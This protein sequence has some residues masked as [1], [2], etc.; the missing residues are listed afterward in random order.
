[1]TKEKTTTEVET[2]LEPM[3]DI[4]AENQYALFMQRNNDELF[5]IIEC[6]EYFNPSIAKK[7]NLVGSISARLGGILGIKD[8]EFYLAGYYANLSL[9]SM[10]DL[11]FKAEFLNDKEFETYKRHTILSSEF[12]KHK[13]LIK[14][15]DYVLNHHENPDASGYF[16]KQS[17]PMESALIN[18]ADVFENCISLSF[19]RPK[20]TLDEALEKTLSVY[21]NELILNKSQ[22]LEIKQELVKIYD[23]AK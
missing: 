1:M 17:Y 4:E 20:Y 13:G 6:L 18:I 2:N 21:S 15:S 16:S 11:A 7:L 14:A 10:Q 3:R 9:L 12:L 19:H 8:S 23:E 5:S 22:I